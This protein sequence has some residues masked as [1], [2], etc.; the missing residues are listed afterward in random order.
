VS[1]NFSLT[2]NQKFTPHTKLNLYKI[3]LKLIWMNGIQIWI[4]VNKSH[5]NKI[6]I[7]QNKIFRLII[8]ATIH[9]SN[10]ILHTD[11]KINTILEDAITSYARCYNSLFDHQNILAK[12]FANPIPGN[13]S[14]RLKR[15]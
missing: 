3:V 11:L 8:K 14:K 13:P 10:Q 12:N 1:L 15:I 2:Q 7:A 9:I 6:Q 5:I 4:S